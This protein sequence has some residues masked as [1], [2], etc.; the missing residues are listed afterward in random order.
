MNIRPLV[1]IA[2]PT[3]RKQLSGQAARSGF[4]MISVVDVLLSA[5]ATGLPAA[6]SSDETL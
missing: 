6:K 4:D 2:R 3:G 5:A 1:S